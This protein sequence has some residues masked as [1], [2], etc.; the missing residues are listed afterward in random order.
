[1][2]WLRFTSVLELLDTESLQRIKL[3]AANNRQTFRSMMSPFW[4][5]ISMVTYTLRGGS[6]NDTMYGGAFGGDTVS[7]WI[8]EAA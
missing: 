7:E 3:D 4:K 2:T 8:D 6:G 5:A 1:M